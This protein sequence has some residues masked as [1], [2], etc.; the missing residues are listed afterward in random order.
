MECVILAPGN[1]IINLYKLVFLD[2]WSLSHLHQDSWNYLWN[3]KI[4]Q[5]LVCIPNIREAEPKEPVRETIRSLH[6]KQMRAPDKCKMDKSKKIQTDSCSSAA[7]LRGKLLGESGVKHRSHFWG[8][9]DR[10]W[11]S[12]WYTSKT[13]TKQPKIKFWTA[14]TV[15]S[16][17]RSTVTSFL[18]FCSLGCCGVRTRMLLFVIWLSPS[19]LWAS[20]FSCEIGTLFLPHMAAVRINTCESIQISNGLMINGKFCPNCPYHYHAILTFPISPASVWLEHFPPPSAFVS[21][22]W[23]KS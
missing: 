17:G 2:I 11:G 21:Y 8:K 23:D 9:S 19:V 4:P 7:R 5:V 22:G 18:C 16:F 12:A 13:K 10:Y 6:R 15:L 14:E 3:M 20:L 1:V